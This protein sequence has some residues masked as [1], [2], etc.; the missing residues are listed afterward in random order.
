M[1]KKASEMTVFEQIKTGLEDAV[2][3][4]RGELSLVTRRV[5]A[6]DCVSAPGETLKETL[7]ACGITQAEFA[8]R[9]GMSRN[10]LRGI[11]N[12]STPITHDMALKFEDALDI[13]AR[14][15]NNREQQY[16]EYLAR[17]AE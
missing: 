9:I 2:A 6:P 5:Y 12:G 13:P 16:R 14:F 4:A 10:R 1:K 7:K 15:W 11:L 3:H 8:R 17:K